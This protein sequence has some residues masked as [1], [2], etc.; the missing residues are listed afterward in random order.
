NISVSDT[1]TTPQACL[2][3]IEG[4]ASNQTISYASGWCN[5]TISLAGASEGNST[6]YVYANDSAG[7]YG[8][9]NSYVV[10]IDDTAPSITI[11]S[12]KTVTNSDVFRFLYS[13][14][15]SCSIYSLDASQNVTNC[16]IVNN[17]WSGILS[18]LSDG[19][20][21]IT[22]WANDS[23]GNM[24][25]V[26]RYWTRDTKPPLIFN[27]SHGQVTDTATIIWDTLEAS[28][29]TIYYGIAMNNLSNTKTD[30]SFVLSH[31]LTLTNLELNKTYYYNVSS[32]DQAGNCNYSGIYNFTTPLCFD[33][34]GDGYESSICGGTDCND[35]NPNIHPGAVDICGNGIDEDCDGS[36]AVC[37]SYTGMGG[38]VCISEWECEE[39]GQCYPNGSQYRKCIDTKR[40]TASAERI[41]MRIC[42]Y[43]LEMWYC[44]DGICNGNE[45]CTTC[46]MDCGTCVSENITTKKC[47]DTD[48]G[49]NKYIKGSVALLT[50]KHKIVYTDYC[51]D[52]R[53]GIEYLC[54]NEGLWSEEFYCEPRKRER[55]VDGACVKQMYCG[56]GICSGNE[57]CATCPVDCGICK[58][59]INTRDVINMVLLIFV[60]LAI[61]LLFY[62]KR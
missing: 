46:P 4:Q 10:W 57:T 8:L 2:V 23:L 3:R 21:N 19:S 20:H 44:G 60:V 48:G 53:H 36:D 41:E 59:K 14:T 62:V 1:L 28:N 31:S 40:C 47:E 37:P 56:D 7:N 52:D 33:K 15:I 50:N 13:E 54:V 49:F 27:V 16:S 22:V 45:T 61:I 35:N 39:W 5:A 42:K 32:C 29:S 24:G 9:N 34:D 51:K 6:I 18:G 12:P 43:E 17:E 55:C 11:I 25:K 30:S 38:G 26:T 58:L